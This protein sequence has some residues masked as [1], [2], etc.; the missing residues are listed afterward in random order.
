MGGFLFD[1]TP[2]VPTLAPFVLWDTNRAAVPVHPRGLEV[3]NLPS[4]KSQS[5]CDETNESRFK[6][7]WCWKGCTCFQQ[8]LK[9][10][11]SKDVFV[12][13]SSRECLPMPV[14]PFSSGL[15]VMRHA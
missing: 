11:V 13:M 10:V 4:T 3:R 12:S 9:L 7:V 8:E 15:L 14:S 1:L 2:A 5:A 6:I